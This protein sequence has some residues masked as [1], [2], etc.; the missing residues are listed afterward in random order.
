MSNNPGP[1]LVATTDDSFAVVEPDGTTSVKIN[2]AMKDAKDP[3]RVRYWTSSQEIYDE[4]GKTVAR[5]T[6]TE[7]ARHICN[8]LIVWVRMKE[9]Q[10]GKSPAN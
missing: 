1:Q 2:M 10:A 6:D 9:R 5:T 7:M 3:Y 8:L 4:S